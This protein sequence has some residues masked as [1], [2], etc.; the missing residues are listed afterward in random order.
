MKRRNNVQG[1]DIP[2]LVAALRDDVQGPI[3]LNE[4]PVLNISA[5]MTAVQE[6]NQ[7]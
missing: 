3:L 2:R 1:T 7:A 4:V 5:V 6:S